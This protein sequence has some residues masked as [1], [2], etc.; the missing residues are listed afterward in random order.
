MNAAAIL[1]AAALAAPA[2]P[3][4]SAGASAQPGQDRVTE[5]VSKSM[6]HEAEQ[7]ALEN[8]KREF[9]ELCRKNEEARERHANMELRLGGARMAG[10][11]V[12]ESDGIRVSR[13]V[14]QDGMSYTVEARRALFTKVMESICLSAGVKLEVVPACPR[15]ALEAR[16]NVHI[17]EGAL[18][19]ILE[20]IAGE[21]GL[22]VDL[23]DA[24]A[25]IGPPGAVAASSMRQ[26]CATRAFRA[27]HRAL[28]RYPDVAAS[29]RAY[30]GIAEYF[31][32]MDQP[33]PAVQALENLVERHG[34]SEEARDAYRLLSIA[35]TRMGRHAE[36]RQA[37]DR[38]LSRAPADAAA[39][40]AAL[41]M[42]GVL[43]KQG[44]FSKALAQYSEVVRRWPGSKE[45]PLALLAKARL[46]VRMGSYPAAL[47]TLDAL[48][49]AYGAPQGDDA[50][51]I[52]AY[53]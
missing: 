6:E 25:L 21:Q 40:E 14:V 37:L 41:K 10:P 11:A 52:E 19:D 26:A 51:E 1:L 28:L 53:L 22:W 15:E 44:D 20:T 8:L 36:A 47:E 31:L 9:D 2:A 3:G 32:A 50:A 5:M 39:P 43:A 7:R 49:D 35:L 45:A 33:A 24:R 30:C 46:C 42:G 27:F 23:D 38:H 34:E 18:L 12:V 16:I 17:R 13:I 48:N 4:A 29:A